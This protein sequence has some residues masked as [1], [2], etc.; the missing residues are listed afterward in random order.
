MHHEGKYPQAR[1]EI[2]RGLG[3]RPEHPGELKAGYTPV[4]VHRP[5]PH[6]ARR[7]ANSWR[8][9]GRRRAIKRPTS[10]LR[11]RIPGSVGIGRSDVQAV[12]ALLL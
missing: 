12:H 9:I 6:G 2:P 1:P 7:L 8:S 3:V 4:H 10:R 5:Y 11:T